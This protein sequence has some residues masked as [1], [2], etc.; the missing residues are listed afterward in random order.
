MTSQLPSAE[1]RVLPWFI[2]KV[3]GLDSE[4]YNSSAALPLLST[5]HVYRTKS[6]VGAV[7]TINTSISTFEWTLHVWRD[8]TTYKSVHDLNMRSILW[9]LSTSLR[10]GRTEA[11]TSDAG[12]SAKEIAKTCF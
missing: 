5:S 1:Y 10:Y 3:L 11:A 9:L 4:Q 8:H 12:A 2:F 6:D 7:K